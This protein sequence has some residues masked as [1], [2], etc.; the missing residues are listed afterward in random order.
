MLLRLRKELKALA[1]PWL[2]VLVLGAW[3]Q[4][5]SRFQTGNAPGNL[6]FELLPIFYALSCALLT[7]LSFG[8]EFQTRTF[9]LLLSQPVT[10]A[11]MWCEK[12][13]ALGIC[14]GS[15]LLVVGGVIL[16]QAS[17]HYFSNGLELYPLDTGQM[18]LPAVV[19]VTMICSAGFWTLSAGNTIGG[20]VF[21]L[22]GLLGAGIGTQALDEAIQRRLLRNG[23]LEWNANV[24]SVPLWIS[25]G[26]LYSAVF[27]WLGWRSFSRLELRQ[28]PGGQDGSGLPERVVRGGT[29]GLLCVRPGGAFGNLLRKELH[30][31]RPIVGIAA[32]FVLCWFVLL[33]LSVARALE[34]GTVETLFGVLTVFYMAIVLCLS[35]CLSLGEEKGLGVHAWHLTQPASPSRQW[36]IKVTVALGVGL[37]AG[38]VLPFLLSWATAWQS[39]APLAI[40]LKDSHGALM[41][42]LYS[43]ATLVASFWSAAL[44]SST[45]RAAVGCFVILAAG[46]GG[47]M[48]ASWTADQLHGLQTP[49]FLALATHR[50]QWFGCC[51]LSGDLLALISFAVILPFMLGQSRWLY[52]RAQVSLRSACVNSALL[53]LVVLAVCFWAFDYRMSATEVVKQGQWRMQELTAALAAVPVPDTGQGRTQVVSPSELA[54]TGRLSENTSKWL[55]SATIWVKNIEQPGRPAHY[56]ATVVFPEGLEIS[57]PFEHLPSAR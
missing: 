52:Q 57:F 35:G 31:Y 25:A 44:L 42:V 15:V 10:R 36:L 17:K 7:A 27:L 6:G 45:V 22:A 55:N 34:P 8:T 54:R 48:L 2:M 19:L 4:I 32:F 43:V 13:A 16:Y 24:W 28:A 14:F 20:A 11:R 49:L 30:F 9:P 40:A 1:V 51:S 50:H 47:V 23:I 18:I 38:V 39:K 46:L 5:R 56:E 21:T 53:I 12:L 33:G 26:I 41:V 37:A 3:V 29:P